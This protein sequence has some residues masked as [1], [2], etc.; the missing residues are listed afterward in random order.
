MSG[1]YTKHFSQDGKVYYYNAS[2]NKSVWSP[3][4]DNPQIIV[5]EAPNLEK[6]T[7][8]LAV[9]SFFAPN[10][11]A[12]NSVPADSTIIP[13]ASYNAAASLAM[14]ATNSEGS[15]KVIQA[16]PPKK[17]TKSRFKVVATDNQ[18]D[19]SGTSAYLKQKSQ[20]ELMA[21]NKGDDNSR[22]HVR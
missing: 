1:M 9:E 11:N 13:G 20:Y 22:C 5:H 21:G 4:T 8:E 2:L 3:P 10:Q 18:D 6:N 17:Q 15:T 16:A 14:N 7:N 19:P 12:Y